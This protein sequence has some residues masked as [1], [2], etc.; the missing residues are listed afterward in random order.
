MSREGIQAEAAEGNTGALAACLSGLMMGA[1]EEEEGMQQWQYGQHDMAR[2]NKGVRQKGG[3]VQQVHSGQC[4]QLQVTRALALGQVRP[5]TALNP[6]SSFVTNPSS[7]CR[8]QSRQCPAVGEMQWTAHSWE[9]G[10]G[11]KRKTRHCKTLA[12]CC[13]FA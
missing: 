4:C 10:V 9:P 1:G 7:L 12:A 5:G 6:E 11:C 13:W 2:A 8:Q 3:L